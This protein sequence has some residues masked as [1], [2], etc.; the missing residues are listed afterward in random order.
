M[1]KS[2][3][4]FFN[5]VKLNEEDKIVFKTKEHIKRNSFGLEYGLMGNDV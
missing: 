3:Y 2:L 1:L 5:N 4:S